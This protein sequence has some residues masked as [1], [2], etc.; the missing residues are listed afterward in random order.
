MPSKQGDTLSSIAF[1]HGTTVNDIM[2]V[3]NLYSSAIFPGQQIIVPTG[4]PALGFEQPAATYHTVRNGDTLASLAL[5]YGTTLPALLQANNLSQSQFIFPGQ[6][7]V[8][9]G[10]MNL[11]GMGTPMMSGMPQGAEM[12]NPLVMPGMQA[13]PQASPQ[14]DQMVSGMVMPAAPQ[15]QGLTASPAPMASSVQPSMP[16]VG[17]QASA[18]LAAPMVPP[19][20]SSGR[21]MNV[22]GPLAPVM[23]PDNAPFVNPE[24]KSAPDMTTQ[25]DGRI[26]SQTQPEDWKYPSV[27]RVNVGGAKGMQVTVSKKGSNSWSTTGFTGT[28]PEYGDGAVEFAPL[29]PGKHVVSLDGQGKGSEV[30]VE[31]KPNSLTYVE[32]VRVRADS[33]PTS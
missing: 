28:K 26:V 9:P 23:I 13:G 17:A 10:S 20:V 2:Q 14:Q 5:R 3:N 1:R 33:G 30:T 8:I 21:P 4:G 15:Q 29:N 31:I 27:L 19:I 11:P 18:P 32:F 24:K 16:L 6:E 22:P 12:S 25:W 7:L